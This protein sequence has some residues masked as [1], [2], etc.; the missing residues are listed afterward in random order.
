MIGRSNDEIVVIDTAPTGHTLLL[1]DAAHSY[2]REL[3][4]S[5]GDISENVK[6]L[7]PRLRNQNETE[8][9]ITTLPE[10]TPVLE[11]ERLQKDLL[12]AGIV[13]HWWVINQSLFA[14]YTADKTLRSRAS[15]EKKW[16]QKVRD[17]LSERMAVIPWLESE[18]VGINQIK[19]LLKK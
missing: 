3:E 18:N 10:A 16:I 17:E 7:L 8:I 5:T 14:A 4:R 9:V 6:E 12:R 11:A 19:Q 1:L 13:P 15:G 2:H